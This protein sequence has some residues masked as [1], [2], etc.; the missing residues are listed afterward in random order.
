VA[1]Y[2][3]GQN[4]WQSWSVKKGAIW[5]LSNRMRH[6]TSQTVLKVMITPDF[7]IGRGVI[8]PKAAAEND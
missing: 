4:E 7:L 2:L 8:P 3:L 5:W 6:E 1:A